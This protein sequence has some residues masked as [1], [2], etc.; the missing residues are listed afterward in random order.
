MTTRDNVAE[1]TIR[2]NSNGEIELG[3]PQSST[4]TAITMRELLDPMFK[5]HPSLQGI[6]VAVSLVGN[7]LFTTTV[8]RNQWPVFNQAFAQALAAKNVRPDNWFEI[9][10]SLIP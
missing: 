1:N 2:V 3:F 7:T 4:H 5:A 9:V 6:R 10:Y 8:Y